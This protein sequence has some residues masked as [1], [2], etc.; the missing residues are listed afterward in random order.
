LVSQVVEAFR[1]HFE[2]RLEDVVTR[3]EH[4]GFSIPRALRDASAA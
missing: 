3:E 2:V 1:A 4:I